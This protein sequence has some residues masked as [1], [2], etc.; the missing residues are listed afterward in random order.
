MGSLSKKEA[1]ILF[2]G[3]IFSFVF[4]LWLVLWIRF[5]EIPSS[6]KFL[7]HLRP[8]S[9]LFLIWILVYFIAGLYEKHTLILKSR[10]PTI[11]FNAQIVNSIFAII[12]FYTIPSFGIAP[13]T[14]LF[15][16]V[17]IS[18]FAVLFWRFYGIY[19]FGSREKQPALLIGSGEEMKELLSEVNGNNRYDLFFVTSFD[20][21][22][23]EAIDIQEDIIKPV[24]SNNVKI[25][26]IDFS[27]EKVSPLLPYLY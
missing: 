25:I 14:I 20:V 27:H 17:F 2:F 3:D 23:M 8:F 19:I 18:F 9:I 7:T 26:A 15:L 10:L 4:S 24:Y 13:K 22:N 12:F 11:V 1:L 6:D 21:H 16:Y 5:A